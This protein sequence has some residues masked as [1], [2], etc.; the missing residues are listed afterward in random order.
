MQ[1]Y[2][3]KTFKSN[4]NNILVSIILL[5]TILIS[6]LIFNKYEEYRYHQVREVVKNFSQALVDR[7]YDKAADYLVIKSG[8]GIKPDRDSKKRYIKKTVE[9]IIDTAQ[10]ASRHPD[11]KDLKCFTIKTVHKMSDNCS[12]TIFDRLNQY[13]VVVTFYSSEN[14]KQDLSGDMYLH[15]AKIG[16][17][18]KIISFSS[19]MG[20]LLPID[21][22]GTK[23]HLVIALPTFFIAYLYIV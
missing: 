21:R 19:P 22:Q 1:K 13:D 2:I 3:L 20:F 8:C 16:R 5:T 6:I 7:D 9:Y 11:F 23:L 15:I 17:E 4:I 10:N 14:F 12:L 18:F